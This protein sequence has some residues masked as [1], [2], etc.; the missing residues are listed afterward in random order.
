VLLCQQTYKTHQNYRL[1]IDTVSFI[2]KTIN[3]IH[4][5]WPT[6]GTKHPAIWY[7]HSLRSPCLP[8]Y[9]APCQ[10]W[11]FSANVESQHT[12]PVR[13]FTTLSQQM[14]NYDQTLLITNLFLAG[15]C[16]G[17]SCM[18]QSNC[19]GANSR[20]LLLVIMA[21]NLTAQQWSP[22][23]MRFRDSHISMSIRY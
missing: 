22:L 3:R 8:W 20:L 19:R 21:F 9:R 7:A 2:H 14:F 1:V 17:T 4:Q 10:L 11:E 12:L 16:T 23:I 6:Q 18:Q 13:H 5:T 15:Q